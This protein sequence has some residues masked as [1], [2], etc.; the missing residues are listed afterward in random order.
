[1]LRYV[2]TSASDRWWPMTAATTPV[3]SVM[4]CSSRHRRGRVL[5]ATAGDHSAAVDDLL[6][7]LR[8][9]PPVHTSPGAQHFSRNNATSCPPTRI[10]D[11]W[12]SMTAP[13]VTEATASHW[14]IR[15]GGAR[16]RV[17]PSWRLWTRSSQVPSVSRTG[18]LLSTAPS[19]CTSG[20][21]APQLDP[22]SGDHIFCTT[23]LFWGRVNSKAHRQ[24]TLHTPPSLYVYSSTREAN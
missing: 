2:A 7:T 11:G 12:W 9:T 17:L 23:E 4:A 21:G 10:S 20:S 3:A 22:P 14:R 8:C 1:M 18:A 6:P 24:V 19:I 15:P 5:M 16:N 13:G